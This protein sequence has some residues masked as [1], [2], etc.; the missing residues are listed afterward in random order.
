[1]NNSKNKIKCSYCKKYLR[2]FSKKQDWNSRYLH[3]KC[4]RYIYKQVNY[5]NNKEL[6]KKYN[7]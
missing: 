5:Y 2:K 7:F 1:M 4:F 3:K 6:K